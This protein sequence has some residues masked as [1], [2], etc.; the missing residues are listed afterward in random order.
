MTWH[1]DNDEESGGGEDFSLGPSE[2]PKKNPDENNKIPCK[3]EK[4]ICPYDHKEI[5][6]GKAKFK[7]KKGKE[8]YFAE[9]Q[10]G[11]WTWKIENWMELRC[12]ALYTID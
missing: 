4:G 7:C 11:N 6:C 2:C 1:I 10:G 5:S 9:K 12:S 3:Q 8:G